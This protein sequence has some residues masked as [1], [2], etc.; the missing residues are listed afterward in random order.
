MVQ[1]DQKITEQQEKA[2]GEATDDEGW[3]TVSGKKKRGKFA[4]VRKESTIQKVKDK[5]AKK[6]PK[7]L[8]DFYAFQ[9]R[10]A[11]K[12]SKSRT[13]EQRHM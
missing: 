4:L 2:A 13:D 3:T 11:K 12:Q 6:P 7:E 8:K 1:Y 5:E 10:E 9:I